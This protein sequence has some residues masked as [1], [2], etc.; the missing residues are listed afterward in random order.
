VPQN[1]YIQNNNTSKEILRTL[2]Y[3]LRGSEWAYY[4]GDNM[5]NNEHSE[6]AVPDFIHAMLN[7]ALYDHPVERCELI[8]THI[9]W[10]ILTGEYVYKIKKPVDFGFLNFSTLAKRKFYCEEE[11]RLNRRLA[12]ELYLEVIHLSGTSDT[13]ILNGTDEPFEYGV[14]MLQFPQEMQLDHVLQRNEL[15]PSM[16]D[17]IARLISNFHQNINVA[18]NDSHFGDPQHIWAPIEE[19]FV[20]ICE[21]VKDLK[22]LRLLAGLYRWSLDSFEQLETTLEQRKRQGF[23]REC[24]GDL[25]LR[26]IAWYKDKSLAFDCLEFNDNFRWIDVINEIAFFVMDLHDHNQHELAQRFLNQYLELTGDYQG[27]LVLRFYMIYRAI[28]RAKV[29]AIRLGQLSEKPQ[30]KEKV[31]QEF[32][33]YLE[34]ASSYKINKTPCIIITRGMSASGKSTLS[35]P[36]LEKLSAIRIR[37]DVERKRLFNIK[38]NKAAHEE[39]GKGIYSADATQA[40][41]TKLYELAGHVIDSGFTVIIDATFFKSHQRQFFKQLAVEKQVGFIILEFTASNETLRK[42]IQSRTNDVSDADLTVLENQIKNWQPIEPDEQHAL[43]TVD[44]ETTFNV[45][46]LVTQIE[47]VLNRSKCQPEMES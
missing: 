15:Q 9:S 4:S 10:V 6:V 28:V 25:H 17:S 1:S 38:A 45:D 20:Q 16:I 5:T 8:E 19:N 29:A 32:L 26:N 46:K 2:Y 27:C 44:T 47:E 7:P 22:T 37:S 39:T 30:E 18:G 3:F 33:N 34:L 43:I 36:L 11:L 13:P 23:I 12:P 42:R 41:Y 31:K 24:H 40:T 21:K 14:K 35:Q